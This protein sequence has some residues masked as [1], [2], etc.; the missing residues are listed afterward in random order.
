M[1]IK[2]L[3]KSGAIK[4]LHEKGFLS[5]TVFSYFEYFEHYMELRKKHTYNESIEQTAEKFRVSTSTIK[6]AVRKIRDCKPHK[7][8]SPWV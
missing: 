4:L 2:H 6:L 3:M 7:Y 1:T 8:A 5:Y